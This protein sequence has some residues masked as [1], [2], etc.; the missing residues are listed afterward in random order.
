MLEIVAIHK[1]RL[2]STDI[3]QTFVQNRNTSK[4][5][6]LIPPNEF[7]LDKDHVF[8]LLKLLYGLSDA[9]DYW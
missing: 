4:P 8:Q 5:V 3:T 6:F 2:W 7:G 9:G 1:F